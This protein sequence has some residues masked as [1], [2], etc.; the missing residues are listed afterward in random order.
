LFFANEFMPKSHHEIL[1]APSE[2]RTNHSEVKSS[3]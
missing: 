1:S 3:E 2:A